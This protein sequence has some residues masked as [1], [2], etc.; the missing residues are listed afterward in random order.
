MPDTI[1]LAFFKTVKIASN[2]NDKSKHGDMKLANKYIDIALLDM[3]KWIDKGNWANGFGAAFIGFQDCMHMYYLR[4]TGQLVRQAQVHTS[5]AHIR[6][7]EN[8]L[9][10]YVMEARRAD[11]SLPLILRPLEKKMQKFDEYAMID[12]NDFMPD[13]S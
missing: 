7:L 6:T 2:K 5:V 8:S 9:R 3:N 1:L 11:K 12:V 13:M 10:V 4:I